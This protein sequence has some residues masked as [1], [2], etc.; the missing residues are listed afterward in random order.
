MRLESILLHGIVVA[1]LVAIWLIAG[2]FCCHYDG[3]LKA[4]CDLATVGGMSSFAEI[5]FALN[6]SIAIKWVRNQFMAYF[7][8]FAERKMIRHKVNLRNAKLTDKSAEDFE[9]Q[10]SMLKRRF[11]SMMLWPTRIY[12]TVGILFAIAIAA[13][14]FSGIPPALKPFVIL[15][16]LPAIAYYLTAVLTGGFIFIHFDSFVH[17]KELPS[18]ADTDDSE[19]D[20]AAVVE[21][22]QSSVKR[23][24]VKPSASAGTKRNGRKNG[25]K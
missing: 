9:K 12:M 1:V 24:K 14:L 7:D 2:G 15:M 3:D 20:I 25:K 17:D 16:P 19:G 6:T 8:S 13:L 10:K 18:E 11:D 21:G 5:S 4:V 22:A 23:S